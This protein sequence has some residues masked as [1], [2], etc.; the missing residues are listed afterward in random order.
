M[1][2]PVGAEDPAILQVA[3]VTVGPGEVYWERFGHN[4]IL[5]QESRTGETRLYHFGVFDFGAE[6]FFLEFIRGRMAYLAVRASTR[7]LHAYRAHGRS[8][9]VQW[10][11]LDP[12]QAHALL[13]HLDEHVQ[14]ENARYR[15]HYYEQN[16]STKLRDA[17]DLATGGAVRRALEGRSRGVTYRWHTR[18]LTAPEPWLFLGTHAGLSGYADRPI[19]YWEEAFIPMEL[20]RR[21]REVEVVDAAGRRV[22]LVAREQRLA[23][24][25]LAPPPDSPRSLRLAFLGVGLAL[26]AGLV[27]LSRVG[28][29]RTLA[30]TRFVLWLVAGVGGLVLAALWLGTEHRS[31]WANENLLLFDPLALA[32]VPAACWARWRGTRAARTIAWLVAAGV[33]FALFAKALPGFR[34]DNLDWIL[35]WLPIHLALAIGLAREP[36]AA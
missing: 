25:K 16:C 6:D 20:A 1:T 21:L 10:L 26:A 7:E 28:A 31:A 22:P 8:V 3:L 2:P 17:L 18:R 15:Y 27:A 14:P 24:A 4:A 12:P 29:R 13:E 19:D 35:L 32:L 33:A 30:V 34:Q 9:D 5:F 36:R 23:E 11:R